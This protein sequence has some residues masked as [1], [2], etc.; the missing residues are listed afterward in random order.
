MPVAGKALMGLGEL[1]REW[2]DLDAATRYVT[3]G[4][5]FMGHYLEI[6]SLLGYSTLA[7]IEQARGNPKAARDL[8]E[9]A[10][11]ADG[12]PSSLIQAELA[13]RLRDCLDQ[14]APAA[15]RFVAARYEQGL[16]IQ[17]IASQEKVNES[18][19]R[20]R[21]FRI[22]QTLKTCLEST[23]AGGIVS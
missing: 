17:E 21:L 13:D 20:V 12:V 6:G 14:L 3:Q 15:R 7:L 11:E 9:L 16:A 4:I 18:T 22:R 2:N 5:D 1:Y 23:L 8:L 10:E 19:A